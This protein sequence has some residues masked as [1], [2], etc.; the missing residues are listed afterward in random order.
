MGT[1]KVVVHGFAGV[2]F[3]VR[4]CQI[5]SFFLIADKKAEG[6]ALYDR[7]LELTDLVVFG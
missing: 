1:D 5:D 6:A 4:T 2:L 3:E 7:D